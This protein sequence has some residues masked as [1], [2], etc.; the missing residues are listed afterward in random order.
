[1]FLSKNAYLMAMS[2]IGT[3]PDMVR[4][5]LNGEI[6]GFR[7]GGIKPTITHSDVNFNLADANYGRVQT[8]FG[9][10]AFKYNPLLD[11]LME[12]L[13]IDALTFKS[14][15]K[16]N[17]LKSKKDAVYN[18]MYADIIG[19]NDILDL[20]KKS[21][22][23]YLQG[24]I[25]DPQ[26]K[27]LELPWESMSLR[28][29][30]KEHDPLVGANTGV[31]MHHDNGIADWIGVDTKI[32]NYN[33]NLANMYSN[34]YYRTALA[35]KVIGT[36]AESGDPSIINS[37]I[38]SILARDGVI[39]EPWAQRRLEDSM[40]GY[41]MNN[42][43]IAG[44]VVPNG[45]LDVMTADMGNLDITIRSDIGGRSTV[46]YYGEFLPSYYAAQKEFIKPGTSLADHNNG[47]HNILIQRGKYTPETGE[48]READMFVIDL[49]GEKY[50]QVEGRG[51]D[52]NGNIIDLDNFNIIKKSDDTNKDVYR[53]AVSLDQAGMNAVLDGSNLAEAALVLQEKN[54]SIGMLNSRQ[55]RNMIGDIVISKMAIVDGKAHVDEASGNVSRMNYSDAIIP[56]D[57][58]FDMDKSFNFVAAPSLFWRE[59]NRLAGHITTDNVNNVLDGLFDP[60]INTGRFAKTLPNL[61]G[62]DPTNDQILHETN[63]ARGQFIKMHQTVTYLANIFRNSPKVLDFKKDFI[64]G[65]NR[66]LSVIMNTKGSYANTVDNISK[67]A[68]E[69]IDV[70]KQLPSKLSTQQIRDM[71][72]KILFGDRESGITGI[73]DVVVEKAD[74]PGD[75]SRTTDVLI[76]DPGYHKIRDAIRNKI[77]D[78]LNVYLKYNRGVY[79]DPSGITY[80][81]TAKN[82]S[83]AYTG[84]LHGMDNTKLIGM[85]P[86]INMDFGLQAMG[87][88]FRFSRNP[89]DISIKGIHE[90]YQKM[91]S[92]K[93]EG[94]V[95]KG[96]TDAQTIIDYID[97]GLEKVRGESEDSKRN[98]VF[99][100]ALNEYVKDE[101]RII[102]LNDLAKQEAHL[103]IELEKKKSFVKTIDISES[104][105]IKFTSDKLDRVRELKKE[106]EEALSYKFKNNFVEQPKTIKHY[107]HK[108]GVLFAKDEAY[109]VVNKS[110]EIKEVILPNRPNR[111]NINKSDK[112]IV[113]GKR[114]QVS[115]GEQ[116]K[117]LR[118][119]FEA[120]SGIPAISD[121]EG[122]TR[123]ITKAEYEYIVRDYKDIQRR[124]IELTPKE[125]REGMID[126]NLE[127][128]RILYDGLFNSPRAAADEGYRKA[129]ILQMLTPNISDKVVSVRSINAGS[130]KKSV[131]DYLYTENSLNEK[132]IGLLS[133]IQTCEYKGDKIFA[134]EMLDDVNLLKTVALLKTENPNIDFDLVKSRLHT[135]PASLDGM[136]T[137]DKILNQDIFEKTKVSDEITRQA[138]EVMVKYAQGKDLVDPI[139]LYKASREIHKKG[140]DYK[141]QWADNIYLADD[142]GKLRQFGI[143]Q[144]MISESDAIRRKDLGERGGQG[145]TSSERIKNLFDCYKK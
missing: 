140:V 49:R 127:I 92:M 91:S 83:D 103:E 37:A 50:V 71:Q 13:G 19:S 89:Y 118:V 34:A 27:I 6:V 30:S 17:T 10:T 94:L 137:K 74:K 18:D 12:S 46:Q 100:I 8:W 99:N 120:F 85:D 111:N 26:S 2:M 5:D 59:S 101:F 52:K 47:A 77:I 116:Q 56:Q 96:S 7:S 136:L 113:N 128:N 4:M 117:G 42:G 123:K 64:E 53:R 82:Y 115:D 55:P 105:D 29:I 41:F 43:G 142:N 143:K 126:R 16:I 14:G 141:D 39:I 57:A 33:K 134:K 93:E 61:I 75:Y 122:S 65:Q 40:I 110:G 35:R 45:S 67:M 133:K 48:K 102:R 28:T 1:M 60:N 11:N 24:N 109:V 54:L 63:K 124:I 44:G 121:G 21:W 38:S 62:T 76:N 72:N 51:I 114:F 129:L 36:Q 68:K 131:Y 108:K 144:R 139:I 73:F 135:E 32:N 104:R 112:I 31:H 3:H 25:A 78:P 87:D 145:E 125:G 23:T 20:G 130:G 97:S 95:N 22:A 98:R 9:K 69:F 79:E 138:A 58:D 70:Y 88:Y 106:M 81:A 66:A 84:L 80:R 119:L 86:N 15:N 132:I 107:G 90:T